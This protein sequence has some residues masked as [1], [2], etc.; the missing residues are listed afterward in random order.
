MVQI[1]LFRFPWQVIN[2]K[3]TKRRYNIKKKTKT[4]FVNLM[5]FR[6]EKG[7]VGFSI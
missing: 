4:F 3:Q 5:I 6:K 1:G 2:S 7:R